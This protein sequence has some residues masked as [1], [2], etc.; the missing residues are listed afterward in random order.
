MSTLPVST[1]QDG[2]RRQMQASREILE[3]VR[4]LQELEENE[5]D[6]RRKQVLEDSVQ[7][8]VNVGLRIVDTARETGK[9]VASL[10][11]L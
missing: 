4:R 11:G 3:V 5:P 1:L 10:M 6:E 9:G 8:L 2:V 7:Q